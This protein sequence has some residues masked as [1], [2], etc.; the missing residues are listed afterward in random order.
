M[1]IDLHAPD[2]DEG[3]LRGLIPHPGQCRLFAVEE[4]TT[5]I[6][7]DCPRPRSNIAGGGDWQPT[8]SSYNRLQQRGRQMIPLLGAPK[9]CRAKFTLLNGLGQ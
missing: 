1:Q 5:A 8:F 6:G 9:R 7:I 4:E 2:I 3:M